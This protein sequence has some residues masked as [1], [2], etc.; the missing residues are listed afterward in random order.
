VNLDVAGGTATYPTS[1]LLRVAY[2]AQASGGQ[3]IIRG[4][5]NDGTTEVT[6][7]Q[8]NASSTINLFELGSSSG[9]GVRLK[10][11]T[12]AA[13]TYLINSVTEYQ[14]DASGLDMKGAGTA[15]PISNASAVTWTNATDPAAPSGGV[16]VWSSSTSGL[17]DSLL[18]IDKNSCEVAVSPAAATATAA[19]YLSFQS[20]TALTGGGGAQTALSVAA[21]TA[22]KNVASGA[23]CYLSATVS[24]FDNTEG[25]A[26]AIMLSIV[27]VMYNSSGTYSIGNVTVTPLNSAGI[28]PGLY[29]AATIDISSGNVRIRVTPGSINV[30]AYVLLNTMG[31]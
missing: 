7:C 8:W 26:S 19:S 21:A 23:Q 2:R 4:F 24:L 10:G 22:A 29:S 16:R 9:A 13:F 5:L 11:A 30:D 28:G 14:I 31:P 15:K 3:Q 1:A 27:A 12:G 18:A 20:K 6:L 25:Y 17:A